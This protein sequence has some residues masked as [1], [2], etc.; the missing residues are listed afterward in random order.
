MKD[1]R[2][3]Y[4]KRI[5]HDYDILYGKVKTLVRDQLFDRRV[6]FEDT[7]TLHNLSNWPLSRPFK[8]AINALT[9]Q[10]KGYTKIHC[11]HFDLL[12]SGFSGKSV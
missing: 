9:V 4:H 3:E 7:N 10:D 8:K 1:L 11:S 2:L 12:L 5:P 6:K